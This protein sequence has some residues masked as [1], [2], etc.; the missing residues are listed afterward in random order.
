M[1]RPK[2]RR[3]HVEGC[4]FFN[5]DWHPCSWNI[6]RKQRWEERLSQPCVARLRLIH[7]DFHDY[8]AVSAATPNADP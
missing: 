8:R 3:R 1:N 4:H 7:K 6:N 2:V 5:F